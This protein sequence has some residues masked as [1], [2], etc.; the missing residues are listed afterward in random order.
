MPPSRQALAASLRFD[1]PL[2]R[3][4]RIRELIE[5][6]AASDVN[7]DVDTLVTELGVALIYYSNLVAEERD[8][9]RSCV[10]ERC[11]DLDG[12]C[13]DVTIAVS[14]REFGTLLHAIYARK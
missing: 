2:P 13:E 4:S 12:R 7:D 11:I 6:W 5:K 14:D 10:H 3:G 8:R 9:R 1:V